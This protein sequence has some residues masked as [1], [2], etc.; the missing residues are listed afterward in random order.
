MNKLLIREFEKIRLLKLSITFS[1]NIQ[2]RKMFSIDNLD[3]NIQFKIST[4]SENIQTN[5]QL[6]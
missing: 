1:V 2:C 6:L 4:Q 5:C 3:K